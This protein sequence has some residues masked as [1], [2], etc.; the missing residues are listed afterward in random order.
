MMS[1]RA[2]DTDAA[3]L[4]GKVVLVQETDKEVQAGTL[5][6]VPLYRKGMP[7]ETIEQR[8]AAIYGWV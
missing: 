7:I 3:A 1:E 8:R 5:M 4:S 2:R 6:Y